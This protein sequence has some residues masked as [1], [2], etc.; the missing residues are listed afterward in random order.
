MLLMSLC[1]CPVALINILSL[2]SQFV[3]ICKQW[4]RDVKIGEDVCYFY[5]NFW[6]L[7][8]RWACVRAYSLVEQFALSSICTFVLRFLSFSFLVYEK[9][10]FP[11]I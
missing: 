11:P 4:P 9:T 6:Y 7:L 3:K 1:G 8:V 5:A 2:G 10:V